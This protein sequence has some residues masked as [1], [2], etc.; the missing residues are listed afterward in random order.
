MDVQ[1]NTGISLT[2]S[3]AM[4]PAA[5]VCGLYFGNPLA[6]YFATGK[7]TKEQMDDYATRKG[8]KVEELERL[9]PNVMSY[10]K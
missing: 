2:E 4:I 10:D 3:L 5:S 7:I 1:K 9:M 6:K 8:M